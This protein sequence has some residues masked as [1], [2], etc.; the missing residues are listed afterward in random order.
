VICTRGP[1]R[2]DSTYL[3]LSDDRE[4]IYAA[5]RPVS[6]DPLLFAGSPVES[7]TD[8]RC[9]PLELGADRHSRFALLLT[10]KV[11]SVAVGDLGWL[12]GR[13]DYGD[14]MEQA[15]PWER[16]YKSRP[17]PGDTQMIGRDA[18]ERTL[19]AAGATIF[20]LEFGPR[21]KAPDDVEQ[22]VFD[23]YC[24]GDGRSGHI[25][26][27]TKARLHMRWSA[28]PAPLRAQMA[29]AVIEKW[30]PLA[31]AWAAAAPKRGN[32]WAATDHDWLLLHRHG[33]LRLTEK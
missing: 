10:E 5:L 24:V 14:A 29:S 12:V 11:T 9:P 15:V 4:D 16:Y 2:A 18:V 33:V 17:A 22:R 21:L 19:V 25:G 23:V 7:I 28:V 13:T 3:S 6:D 31:C 32:T 8:K 1:T 26:I 30:L 27:D 20:S